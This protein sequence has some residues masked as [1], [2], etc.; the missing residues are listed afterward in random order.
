M[1]S[2]LSLEKNCTFCGRS[3]HP[4]LAAAKYCSR[5]CCAQ[6]RRLNSPV[7][8]SALPDAPMHSREFRNAYHRA[9]RAAD[10]DRARLDE[11]A[12][13]RRYKGKHPDKIREKDRRNGT[14]Y[15]ERHREKIRT[16]SRNAARLFRENNGELV[17]A[18]GRAAYA[19]NPETYRARGR[20]YRQNNLQAC[21]QRDRERYAAD[22]EKERQAS[23]E[24]RLRNLEK[25]RLSRRR[26]YQQ[27]VEEERRYAK[28]YRAAHPEGH[29]DYEK[30]RRARKKGAPI[31]DLSPAQWREIQE[32]QK[33]RCYYCQKRC[34]GRL[35]QDHILALS[36]GGSHTAPNVI[37]VCRSCNSRKGT[38]PPPIPV[39][40]LLLTCA[41][42][43]A[44]KAS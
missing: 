37:G 15:R 34:K 13:Y 39:Q 1:A 44:P 29:R 38:R 4:Y 35:T 41:P 14:K 19:A 6:H 21:R 30:R 2:R 5:S 43:K 25:V 11:R 27:N 12:A 17:R 36:Q 40:P 33:H 10:P 26:F 32:V 20:N 3:F 42:P 28:A 31:N 22:P 18:R 7:E 16:K 24:Y 9:R 23:R 8:F